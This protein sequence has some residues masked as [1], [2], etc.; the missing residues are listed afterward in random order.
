MEC[1]KAAGVYAIVNTH[2][3]KVYIGSAVNIHKRFHEHKHHLRHNNHHSPRLQHSYNKHGKET[4]EYQVMQYCSVSELREVEQSYLDNTQSYLPTHGYNIARVAA[5]GRREILSADQLQT[6]KQLTLDG[7]SQTQIS[8][9][10]SIPTG[11]IADYQKRYNCRSKHINPHTQRLSDNQYADIRRLT[12]DGWS[13]RQIS[14]ELNISQHT[15]NKT[16]KKLGIKSK[17]CKSFE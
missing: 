1:Q 6:L 5:G 13:Q 3:G 17:R 7:H 8:T 12:N 11:T 10:M 16:Q 14:R 15:I 4:F 9:I 2:N